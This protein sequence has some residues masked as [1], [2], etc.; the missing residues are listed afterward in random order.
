MELD[1]T[2]WSRGV[3]IVCIGLLLL[4]LFICMFLALSQTN[5]ATSAYTTA[6]LS[7]KISAACQLPLN[8]SRTS[9]GPVHPILVKSAVTGGY[10]AIRSG[11]P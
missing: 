4:I 7:N 8:A 1:V 5:C 9:G 10:D 2:W 3:I 11:H 6:N